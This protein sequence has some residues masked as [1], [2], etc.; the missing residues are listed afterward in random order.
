MKFIF[1]HQWKEFFRS[2]VWQKNLAINIVMALFFVYIAANFVFLSYMAGDILMDL[3]PGQNPIDNFNKGIIYYFLADIFIRFYMQQSP[4]V[5]IAQYLH[6]PIKK[7]KIL[8]L[9]LL[10][11]GLSIFNSS[12]LLLTIPFA[13]GWVAEYESTSGAVA[14]LIA[15]VSFNLVNS[16][17][18]IYLKKLLMEKP[19]IVAIFGLSIVLIGILDYYSILILTTYS[20]LF[21]TSI[22]R[23]EFLALIPVVMLVLTYFGVFKFFKSRAYIENLGTLKK[24]DAKSTSL[25]FLEPLAEI[26]KLI[27][28][29]LKL[30]WRNKRPKSVTIVSFVFF[31]YG[32]MLYPQSTNVFMLIVAGLMITGMFVLNYGQFLF[33]WESS[34]F[35]LLM[36]RNVQIKKYV[37]G[38]FYLFS[39]ITFISFL[40]SLIYIPYGIEIIQVNLAMALFNMGINFW[41]VMYFSTLNPKKID[42]SK[43]TFFNY[44]GTSYQQFIIVLPMMGLPVFV[45]APFHVLVSQE[46]GI[47]ALAMVGILGILL[48]GPLSK[49]VEQRIITKKYQMASNFRES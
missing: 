15:L 7:H 6:L 26:G 18:V 10:R 29:E 22:I 39:F 11:S 16:Y 38:K 9:V 28:L 36:A 49:I 34:Y 46:A 30:I 27:E 31:L 8:N 13:F 1:E 33:S 19:Y 32:Y 37:I 35:D 12:I 4:V 41:V 44:Q 43:S 2:S 42:L 3:F 23:N 48:K 14:W 25:E 20:Q 5:S 40:L 45:F 21:F 47:L 17:L 24:K